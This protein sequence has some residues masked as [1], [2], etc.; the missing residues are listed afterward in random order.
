MILSTLRSIKRLASVFITPSGED[1]VLL[2]EDSMRNTTMDALEAQYYRAIITNPW[3]KNHL[4]GHQGRFWV[5]AG[6]RD[7]STVIASDLVQ[8]HGA[9]LARQIRLQFQNTASRITI[10]HCDPESGTMEVRNIKSDEHLDYNIN[11]LTIIWNEGI[12]KKVRKLRSP[13]ST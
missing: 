9:N 4:K 12:Q 10:W 2:L 13:E 6:C 5:G 1:S 7:I 8:L 3:G 11:S